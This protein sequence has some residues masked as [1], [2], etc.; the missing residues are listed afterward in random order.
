M[1]LWQAIDGAAKTRSGAFLIYQESSLVIGRFA[2][3]FSPTSAS[4]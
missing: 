3:T 4:S 1:Q 2:T